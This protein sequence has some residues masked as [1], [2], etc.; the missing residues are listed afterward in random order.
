MGAEPVRASP[1]FHLLAL[2]WLQVSQ[3]AKTGANGNE[4]TG[5]KS[6][7]GMAFARV[8]T[9]ALPSFIPVLAADAETFEKARKVSGA[10]FHLYCFLL[11]M[12]SIEVEKSRGSIHSSL[13]HHSQSL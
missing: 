3:K 12:C 10:V 6:A 2:A 4:E 13:N 7:A 9:A 11:L 8:I 1:R 5:P